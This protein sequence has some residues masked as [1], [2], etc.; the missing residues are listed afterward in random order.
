MNKKKALALGNFDG[1]H[2]GHAEVIKKITETKNEYEP[3]ALLFDE[4]PLKVLRG[5][6]PPLLTTNEERIRIL[7]E[8]GV[9]PIIIHFSEIMNLSPEEFVGNF[10]ISMQVG[11]VS[12]GNNYHFAKNAEGDIKILFEL[13]KKY[14]ILLSV[15]DDVTYKGKLISSSRIR[16]TLCKGMV[17][18]ANAMLGRPYS[19]TL[20]VSQG[21]HIGNTLGF[22]TINQK[23]PD[24]YIKLRFGVYLTK[25]FTNGKF[26][27][28]ITNF[29]VRP[30]IGKS[31]LLSETYILDFD[32]K[33]YGQNVSVSFIDFMRDEKK[34]DSLEKLKEQIL[35]DKK[36]AVRFFDS[37]IYT[38]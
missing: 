22:P 6:D 33:L 3:C 30:T 36:E 25:V 37:E 11:A 27:P 8:A 19:Y 34:F 9:R 29:G 14:D 24:E 35:K 31:D 1:L 5:I 10:L 28:A 2:M 15:A 17:K 18:D 26:Y 20:P 16:E 38:N 23:I 13:S 32:E 12:C 4:H 21:N 7:K